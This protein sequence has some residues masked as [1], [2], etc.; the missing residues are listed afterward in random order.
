MNAAVCTKPHSSAVA[1]RTMGGIRPLANVS[2]ACDFG[3]IDSDH[4]IHD[5][6]TRSESN[7]Q[8]QPRLLPSGKGASANE[9]TKRPNATDRSPLN[10]APSLPGFSGAISNVFSVAESSG[11][12]AYSL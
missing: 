6:A 3:Q 7:D 8:D 1:A 12:S 2:V 9:T 5:R 10:S 4:K 11:K